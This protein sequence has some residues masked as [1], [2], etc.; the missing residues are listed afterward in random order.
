LIAAALLRSLM[1]SPFV[2]SPCIICIGTIVPRR[3]VIAAIGRGAIVTTSGTVVAAPER[4][5]RDQNGRDHESAEWNV[6]CVPQSKRGLLGPNS[7]SGKRIGH[8]CDLPMAMWR[9][10]GSGC[11]SWNLKDRASPK[12]RLRDVARAAA[13]SFIGP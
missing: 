7:I 4:H 12:R 1:L 2:S 9:Q 3:R 13:L 10:F 5:W 6:H 8:A 11:P